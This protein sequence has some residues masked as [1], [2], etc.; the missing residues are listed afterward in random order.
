M[1]KIGLFISVFLGFLFLTNTVHASVIYSQTDDSASQGITGQAIVYLGNIQ[2][3]VHEIK[4]HTST[5]CPNFAT[6]MDPTGAIPGYGSFWPGTDSNSWTCS[7]GPVYST[8]TPNTGYSDPVLNDATATYSLYVDV[9]GV[10]IEGSPYT[11]NGKVYHYTSGWTLYTGIDQAYVVIS[12]AAPNT[13]ISITDP[14]DASSIA[15]FGLGSGSI[16]NRDL[17]WVVN[18]TAP[19]SSYDIKVFYGNSSGVSNTS[20]LYYDSNSSSFNGGTSSTVVVAKSYL[21]SLGDWYAKAYLF[22]I[23][24]SVPQ[25]V[26]SSSEIHFSIIGPQQPSGAGEYTPPPTIEC[27]GTDYVCQIENWFVNTIGSIAQFLLVPNANVLQQWSFLWDAIKQKAPIGYLSIIVNDVNN[28]SSSGDPSFSI[29][30][31][32]EMSDVIGPID[33]LLTAIIYL[34]LAFWIIKR[35]S[36]LEL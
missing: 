35:I 23:S 13:S 33:I 2:G 5:P 34:F 24:G 17:G 27:G 1:K 20:Y 18:A 19:S 9:N 16:I 11:G 10:N 31:L 26:A 25:I 12:D 6:E 21:L 7:A 22:D 36:R 8:Y 32:S 14:S 29:S 4:I 28:L 15:D 30:E 3:T